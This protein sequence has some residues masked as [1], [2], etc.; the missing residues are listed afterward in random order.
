[1]KK[2]KKIL[3]IQTAFIG[4]VILATSFIEQVKKTFP[5]EK[6]IDFLLRGGNEGLLEHNPHIRKIYVWDKK[7]SKT[8][9]L[10]RIIKDVR[11]EKYDIIFNIQRFFST[12]L[13]CLLSGARFKVGFDKNPLSFTYHRKIKHMIPDFSNGMLYHEVDRNAKLL[14]PFTKTLLERERPNLYLDAV[15][16]TTDKNNYVVIAPASV[17][18]TKKW[19]RHKWTELS[20]RLIKQGLNVFIIGGPDDFDYC[21]KIVQN[22]NSDKIQNLCGKV[23]LI[24]SALLMRNAK[25]VIVNDSA[26]LHL[27]SAMNAPTTAIFCSTI[28]EFGYGPLAEDSVVI[29]AGEM[30]CRPCGVHGKSSCPLKH[31]NCGEKILVSDVVA[32]V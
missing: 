1:M 24:Q 12:G 16:E 28:P 6:S 5:E 19:A 30:S 21:D 22:I 25:R 31:F 4:D 18:P 2:P 9:S 29:D 26:P 27:A 13:I 32:S 8:L 11:K 17:W 3:I 10:F 7:N 20:K 23:S 14:M 15:E